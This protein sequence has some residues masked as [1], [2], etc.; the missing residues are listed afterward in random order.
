M[1]Q[2]PTQD[3]RDVEDSDDRAVQDDLDFEEPSE[4]AS[5]NW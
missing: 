1:N 3:D 5:C 4:R 2:Q